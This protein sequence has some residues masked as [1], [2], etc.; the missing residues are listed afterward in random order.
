MTAKDFLDLI[1]LQIQH[2]QTLE[3]VEI[4]KESAIKAINN[5]EELVPNAFMIEVIEKEAN[6]AITKIEHIHTVASN[7]K[8]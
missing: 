7:V 1:T 3:L 6:K 2:A 5:H 8:F 4:V